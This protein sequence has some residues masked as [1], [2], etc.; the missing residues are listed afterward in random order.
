MID[1]TPW[2]P[3][4]GRTSLSSAGRTALTAAFADVVSIR[5]DFESLELPEIF[6]APVDGAEN[7]ACRDIVRLIAEHTAEQFLRGRIATFARPLNGGTIIPLDTSLWEIDDPLMR[8]ATGAFN[9]DQWAVPTA[10]LTHR[11]FVDSV[12]FD[13]WLLPQRPPGELSS[14]QIESILDPRVRAKV[15]L[16][17]ANYVGTNDQSFDEKQLSSSS[18]IHFE[19]RSHMIDRAEV[20]RRTS[21]SRSTIYSY[22]GKGEFPQCFPLTNNR[23]AWQASEIDEWMSKKAANRGR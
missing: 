21:L 14:R 23:V 7:D 18:T 8:F 17:A 16:A 2:S 13:R 11:L 4:L 12:T 10:E 19:E 20:E 5:A 9:L 15:S 1:I 3:Y 6:D 22:M